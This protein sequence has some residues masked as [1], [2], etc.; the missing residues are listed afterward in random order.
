MLKVALIGANGQLGTDI[1]KVFEKDSAFHLFPLTKKDL[2]VTVKEKTAK[3]L[4]E[5]KPDFGA[6]KLKKGVN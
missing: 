6:M 1:L 5:I 2:D 4:K 3:V